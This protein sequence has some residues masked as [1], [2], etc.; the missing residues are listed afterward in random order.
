MELRILVKV[1]AAETVLFKSAPEVEKQAERQNAKGDISGV[2]V[3]HIVFTKMQSVA[4][5]EDTML[6]DA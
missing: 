1:H 2:S 6:L 3:V 5:I 4:E